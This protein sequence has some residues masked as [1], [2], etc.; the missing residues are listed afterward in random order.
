MKAYEVKPPYGA[1]KDLS[2]GNF[3]VHTGDISN[4]KRI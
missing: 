4:Y 2:L 3:T 1:D